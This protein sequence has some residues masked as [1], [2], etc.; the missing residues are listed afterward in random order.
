MAVFQRLKVKL[1]LVDLLGTLVVTSGTAL[2]LVKN[3]SL[4]VHLL[5]NRLFLERCDH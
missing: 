2:I 4:N 5:L 3:Y 1:E